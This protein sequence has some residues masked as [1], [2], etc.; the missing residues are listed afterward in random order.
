M[1]IQLDL[2]LLFQGALT[3]F[4]QLLRELIPP[5]TIFFYCTLINKY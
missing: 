5:P 1:V 3:E 4:E 2:V